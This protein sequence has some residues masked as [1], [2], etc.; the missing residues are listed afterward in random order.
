MMPSGRDTYRYFLD[1][2]DWGR[3]SDLSLGAQQIEGLETV[4]R[5]T[6][7]TPPNRATP[8]L[9]EDQWESPALHLVIYSSGMDAHAQEHGSVEYRLTKHQP[10]RTATGA[11]HRAWRNCVWRPRQP[12]P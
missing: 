5:R 11:V 2:E 1:Y 8:G 3:I 6:T 12:W 4:G 9:V 7:I 10:G